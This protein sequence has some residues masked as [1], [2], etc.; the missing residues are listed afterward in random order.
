MKDFSIGLRGFGRAFGFAM[1]NG[2]W[3]MFLVPVV[4]WLLFASGILW[5]STEAVELVSGWVSMFWDIDVPATD[6]TGMEGA[7]DDAKGFLNSARDVI[8]LFAVKAALWFLFGLVG[9]YLVLI[10]LSPLLAYASERTEEIV[11][12]LTVPFDLGQF[13]RDVGRG[14]VMA[15]RNGFNELSIA[16]VLWA[17]TLFVAVLAPVTAVVLWLI[18]SWF[19]GFSM[20]DY[21]FERQRMGIGASAHAARERRGIVLANGMLFNFLMNP[22]F[23]HWVFGPLFSGICFCIVPVVASIGA[24]LSWHEAKNPTHATG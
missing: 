2:L 23:L 22:P 8:V 11:T 14:I 16:V 18:S 5:V 17:C 1:R 6:R 21:I 9:K 4:L 24:V 3:W 19:Y 13:V 15:L 20:F 12:G 7:W 10:L